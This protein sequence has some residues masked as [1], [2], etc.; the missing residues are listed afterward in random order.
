[1][2]PYDRS[3]LLN[4]LC[5]VNVQSLTNR[6]ERVLPHLWCVVDIQV[7]YM[8]HR[9]LFDTH[10]CCALFWLLSLVIVRFELVM[11]VLFLWI[12]LKKCRIIACHLEE[13][14]LG[15]ALGIKYRR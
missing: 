11:V 2:L 12:G 10:V 1:M 5:L 15:F 6:M 7:F 3:S 13:P 8:L 4:S 14:C 9:A